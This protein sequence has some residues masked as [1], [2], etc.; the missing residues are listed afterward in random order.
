M[1]GAGEGRRD[2]A[3]GNLNLPLL[4]KEIEL[5]EC[6]IPFLPPLDMSLDF[7][8]L[9]SGGGIDVNRA[10]PPHPLFPEDENAAS[11]PNSTVSSTSAGKRVGREV[12]GDNENEGER[13]SCSRGSDE[14]DGGAGG[15]GGGVDGE[16][17]K[18]LRLS[19]EQSL[20]LEEMFKE[21]STLNPVSGHFG[22]SNK[23]FLFF[24]LKSLSLP[25]VSTRGDADAWGLSG[26]TGI[27]QKQ[28]LALAEQLNLRPRQVEVWFQNRRARSDGFSSRTLTFA[29]SLFKFPPYSHDLYNLIFLV[30][31]FV[32]TREIIYNKKIYFSLNRFGSTLW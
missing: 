6:I 15:G 11:S 5:Y 27:L 29:P 13:T 12:T 18:K 1:Q 21:H 17:R 24:F 2:T 25:V 20:V 9:Q 8:P 22:K 16:G 4:M 3:M 31:C 30:I 23:A 32:S 10:P 7:R 26:R 19:R 14:D 28:K